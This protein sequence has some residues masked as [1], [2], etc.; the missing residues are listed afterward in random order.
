MTYDDVIKSAPAVLIEFF[1][2]WCGHCQRMEPVVEDI[3]TL[4]S[5]EVQLYQLDID[6]NRDVADEQHIEGTPTFILYKNGEEVWR[7]SGEIDGNTLLAK[8]QHYV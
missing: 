4:L 8:I 3:K 1:A 2:T 6:E 7:L 5:G